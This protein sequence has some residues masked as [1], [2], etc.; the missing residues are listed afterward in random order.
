MKRSVAIPSLLALAILPALAGCPGEETEIEYVATPTKADLVV[1]DATGADLDGRTLDCGTTD[2]GAA[3]TAV[4]FYVRNKG[5]STLK[6]TGGGDITLAVSGAGASQFTVTPLTITSIDPGAT[7]AVSAQ[8]TPGASQAGGSLSATVT[9]DSADPAQVSFDLSGTIR[10]PSIASIAPPAGTYAGGTAITIAGSGFQDDA[11]VTVGGAAA[12][13]V[14]VTGNAQ[15]TCTTPASTLSTTIGFADVVVT[16]GN[17]DAATATGGFEY[18][19]LMLTMREDDDG[20]DQFYA[21]EVGVGWTTETAITAF[22]TNENL[23]YCGKAGNLA[24]F[25][26]E[27]VATS[28][29]EYDA[30]DVTAGATTVTALTDRGNTNTRV[31]LGVTSESTPRI[32]FREQISGSWYLFTA[33]VDGSDFSSAAG[34]VACSS[35]V[36]MRTGGLGKDFVIT[37]ETVPRIVFV[38]P[39]SS[40][41]PSLYSV[42]VDG[43]DD[44]GGEDLLYASTTATLVLR[45]V[46][47]NVVS[48]DN[49]PRAVFMFND[50]G[51]QQELGSV[52]ADGGAAYMQV[53]DST[54]ENA[55][56]HTITGESTP[57]VIFRR[58]PAPTQ[59]YSILINQQ[60][61]PMT[62]PPPPNQLTNGAN[63]VTLVSET[64]YGGYLDS[65]SVP[66]L[67]FRRQI[68]GYGTG[69]YSVPVDNH[70]SGALEAGVTLLSDRKD[71]SGCAFRGILRAAGTDRVFWEQQDNSGN[72]QI[73]TRNIDGT[74]LITQLTSGNDGGGNEDSYLFGSVLDRYVVTSRMETTAP[75]MTWQVFVW[76]LQTSSERQLTHWYASDNHVKNP[77]WAAVTFAAAGNRYIGIER[78]GPNLT[79]FAL[80]ADTGVETQMTNSVTLAQPYASFP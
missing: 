34:A 54:S 66:N 79:A 3:G 58:G 9:V 41:F 52:P 74:G 36:D 69:I 67:V 2:P 80:A 24:I 10:L 16:N 78:P 27:P 35:L 77:D 68:P 42:R 56:F 76:D 73:R 40:G 32:V 65:D 63:S 46:A 5:G 1:E 61:N 47:T 18:A 71:S 75:A 21:T 14:T 43:Q 49:A 6:G 33:L 55:V 53:T 19:G 44:N 29:L 25:S 50:T 23:S 8:L 11:T 72:I 31:Y 39:S 30:V 70:T 7:A 48:P 64:Y 62:A 28:I 15:I 38:H 59:I 37:N 12:T 20:I 26:R 60:E 51:G 4:T 45:G 57:R 17:G 22:T 13:G